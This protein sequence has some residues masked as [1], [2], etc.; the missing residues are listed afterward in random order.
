M[1]EVKIRTF[2]AMRWMPQPPEFPR[3][4]SSR[5]SRSMSLGTSSVS[6]RP[7]RSK[8]TP[9]QS[10]TQKLTPTAIFDHFATKVTPKS[11]FSRQNSFFSKLRL[12]FVDPSIPPAMESFNGG[13]PPTCMPPVNTQ[14]ERDLLP[15]VHPLPGP[16]GTRCTF[17]Q[18]Y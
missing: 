13:S 2:S 6:V 15:V 7:R 9:T 1:F 8:I 3:K 17:T 5:A 11:C 18:G 14:M 10:R 12:K 16:K 4:T